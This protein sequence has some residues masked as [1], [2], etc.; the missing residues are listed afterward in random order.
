MPALR[1]YKVFISHSWAYSDDYWRVVQFL[2][3]APNFSWMNLS[4]PEHA[5]VSNDRLEYELRNQMRPADAF[6]IIAG[7]YAGHREWIDFELQF[8]RRTGRPIIGIE[9]W[10]SERT[11][12]A[13][14]N[15]ATTTVGWNGSS[16]VQAIRNHALPS[17][18]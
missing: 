11:P 16:I 13:I 14:Q 4:V 6:L 2:N 9:K 5:P 17:L 10:G 8:A 7:M 15:A 1:T 12:L 18:A 3:E